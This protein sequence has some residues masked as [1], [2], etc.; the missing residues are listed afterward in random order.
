VSLR[1]L[2]WA[3]KDAP[4]ED[5]AERVIL[6][7]LADRSQNGVA[8]LSD[9]EAGRGAIVEPV[10]ALR[11][12]RSMEIRGLL[13]RVPP[14]RRPSHVPTWHIRAPHETDPILEAPAVD[15]ASVRSKATMWP[16]CWICGGPKDAIDH[17]KPRA[18]GGAHLLCN[19]RPI[20][21]GCNSAKGSRWYGPRWAHAIAGAGRP[22]LDA[23]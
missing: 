3:L 10:E 7:L 17:V 4:V 11:K 22:G 6:T 9:E 19:L 21:T 2:A 23:A 15:A 13:Q 5:A 16:G 20:C 12:M 1:T 8:W 14:Q 18:R